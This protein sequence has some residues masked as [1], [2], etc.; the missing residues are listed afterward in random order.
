M[1]RYVKRR[2]AKTARFA[3]TLL[4]QRKFLSFEVSNLVR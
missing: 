3:N 4:D 2:R 1:V